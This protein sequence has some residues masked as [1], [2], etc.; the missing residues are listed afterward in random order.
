MVQLWKNG[1]MLSIITESEANQ[2]VRKGI[3]RKINSQAI[4]WIPKKERL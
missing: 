4:D 1:T 3:Y 2:L